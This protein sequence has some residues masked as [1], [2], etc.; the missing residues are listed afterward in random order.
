MLASADIRTVQ[1]PPSAR[2]LVR[3]RSLPTQRIALGAIEPRARHD[4]LS[5]LLSRAVD[6]RT[7]DLRALYGGHAVLQRNGGDYD[8]DDDY[9]EEIDPELEQYMYHREAKRHTPKLGQYLE[10]LLIPIRKAEREETRKRL[11]AARI[12]AREQR[13]PV[14]ERALAAGEAAQAAHET[15]A[16]TEHNNP[17]Y[18]T[19]WEA[20]TGHVASQRK[21]PDSRRDW[22]TWLNTATACADWV[23]RRTRELDEAERQRARDERT[24]RITGRKFTA[25]QRR[26]TDLLAALGPAPSSYKSER[27][28]TLRTLRNELGA[29]QFKIEHTQTNAYNLEDEDALAA[30]EQRA[31]DVLSTGT[32]QSTRTTAGEPNI[33]FTV[34]AE[35][36]ALEAFIDGKAP[37]SSTK[38]VHDCT[39]VVT[40]HKS[41][42]GGGT[43]TQY[44]GATVFHI[45]HGLSSG[46][47]GC[48]VFYTKDHGT[49]VVRVVGVGQHVTGF[50]ARY[51]LSFKLSAWTHATKFVANKT[52]DLLK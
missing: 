24:R 35:E 14:R 6:E 15:L 22:G 50:A 18:K 12:S 41:T 47:D 33:T 40:N 46:T 38:N 7:A 26:L 36:A 17:A 11:K 8:Y 34:P 31:A 42:S 16:A 49:G 29:L 51:R 19:L 48:T 3:A 30:L 5:G 52:I 43:S 25:F 4:R 23:E 2:S 32:S 9:D 1:A 27:A 21:V 13:R 10:P 44:Q 37:Y 45:S 39:S 28:R 20:F